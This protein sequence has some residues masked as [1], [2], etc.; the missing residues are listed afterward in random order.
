ML[1]LKRIKLNDRKLDSQ[2]FFN[3]LQSQSP[4]N[5]SIS[6]QTSLSTNSLLEDELEHQIASQWNE[7]NSPKQ[8]DTTSNISDTLLNTG[9]TEFSPST[10]DGNNKTTE[11]NF[12]NKI[13][14]EGHLQDIISNETLQKLTNTITSSTIIDPLSVLTQREILNFQKKCHSI[15]TKT[16]IQNLS[17]R[18][19][20]S[21]VSNA[22]NDEASPPSLENFPK[23]SKNALFGRL[24]ANGKILF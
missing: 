19:S 9:E 15:L 4:I 10:S 18:D 5:H 17:H 22:Y 23:E 20:K 21:P 13:N 14:S 7:N 1:N 24:V 2:L 6:N 8:F 16:P 3:Q 12:L 11:E